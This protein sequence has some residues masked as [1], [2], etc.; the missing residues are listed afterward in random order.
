MEKKKKK[1]KKELTVNVEKQEVISDKLH[2]PS[3][4]VELP[5]DYVKRQEEIQFE[6]PS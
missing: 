4:G 5:G 1:S 2:C 6:W 3:C